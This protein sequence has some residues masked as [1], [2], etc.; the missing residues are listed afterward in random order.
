MTQMDNLFRPQNSNYRDVN[1][2]ASTKDGKKNIDWCKFL[3]GEK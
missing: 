3:E 1:L 2:K